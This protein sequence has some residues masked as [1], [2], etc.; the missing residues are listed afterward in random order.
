VSITFV[1]KDMK[2]PKPSENKGLYADFEK[3]LVAYRKEW[4]RSIRVEVRR[5]H[6]GSKVWTVWI[7]SGVQSFR[8]DY[9]GSYRECVWMKRML[10]KAGIG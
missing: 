2:I 6:S 5:Q 7:V 1:L 8:L 4:E 3:Y 9:N 10:H